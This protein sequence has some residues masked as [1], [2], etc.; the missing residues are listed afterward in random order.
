MSWMA[1][2]IPR[3]A[4]VGMPARCAYCFG[5]AEQDLLLKEIRVLGIVVAT[6]L[7]LFGLVAMIAGFDAP[8]GVRIFFGIVAGAILALLGLLAVGLSVR[9]LPRYR[10]WGAGLLGVDLAA[11]AEA[12]T[13]RF[14]NKTFAAAFRTR[15]G[16]R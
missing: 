4:G 14:T 10:D 11:G 9:R 2:T 15:N 3:R 5:T 6:L 13:F 16:L 1:V 8:L 12:L 7:G